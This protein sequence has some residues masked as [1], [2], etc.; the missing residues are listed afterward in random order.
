MRISGMFLWLFCMVLTCSYG[1][2]Q[3]NDTHA[4]VVAYVIEKPGKVERGKKFQISVL[5][6]TQPTWYIYAPT[7]NNT[8]Q[9]M[10]E[11]GVKFILPKGITRAGK[12][13]IPKAIFKH[14]NEIYEGAGIRM[15]QEFVADASLKAGT[16]TIEAEVTWQTCNSEICL[17]PVKESS[18]ATINIQ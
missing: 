8:A 12:M 2:A 7:G 15:T 5:F 9:G 4:D 10:I 1:Y 3:H 13:K 17:P 14:G 6:T 11:S 18:M 16:Y